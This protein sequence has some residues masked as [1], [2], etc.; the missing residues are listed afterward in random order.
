[1]TP[2]PLRHQRMEAGEAA[3]G[4]ATAKR[5]LACPTEAT[6]P[7][8]RAAADPRRAR[9][10]VACRRHVQL[11]ERQEAFDHP[12]FDPDSA[13]SVALYVGLDGIVYGHDKVTAAR[14]RHWKGDCSSR[15]PISS[16][17]RGMLK[18]IGRRSSSP[19]PT[20]S[21]TTSAPTSAEEGQKI[22][23]LSRS[24][25]PAVK[26]YSAEGTVARSPTGE[27]ALEHSVERLDSTC[28]CHAATRVRLPAPRLN[29]GAQF[30]RSARETANREK[31]IYKTLLARPVL[32]SS[33][34]PSSLPAPPPPSAVVRGA[35]PTLLLALS[36][37]LPAAPCRALG[38]PSP[39]DVPR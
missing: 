10:K 18:D 37:R 16:A 1:V 39:V 22:L 2:R 12:A 4:P 25:R 27:V 24:R 23:E 38:F 11:Q 35:V 8:G 20:T 17:K 33:P 26:I 34:P 6:L 30:R 29:C 32:P 14:S 36:R 31:Q 3:G 5:P 13:Y 9:P 7:A 21:A 19:R 15:D 28:P